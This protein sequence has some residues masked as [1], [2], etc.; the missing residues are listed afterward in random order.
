MSKRIAAFV[1]IACSGVS[2]A[3]NE[4]E[5]V[6]RTEQVAPGVYVLYG[7][8]GNIGVSAGADGVFLIDDQ[9]A[10]VTLQVSE[11]LAK[12]GPY[13]PRFVLNTHWHGDHTG[14]NEILAAK[15]TCGRRARSGPCPHECR[16]V[17]AS[18][19]SARPRRRRPAHCRS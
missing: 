18:S 15:G 6:V 17:F 10:A 9:Y 4:P 7:S 2:A 5:P 13:P 12:I 19:S 14:G 1:L 3:Q 11:A 16:P 8:G